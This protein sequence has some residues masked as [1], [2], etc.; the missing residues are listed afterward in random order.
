[1]WSTG[2]VRM[3]TPQRGCG[4]GCG[5]VTSHE[6]A[7]WNKTLSVK[8]ARPCTIAARKLNCDDLRLAAGGLI[9]SH[10]RNFKDCCDDDVQRVNVVFFPMFFACVFFFLGLRNLSDDE[11]SKTIAVCGGLATVATPHNPHCTIDAGWLLISQLVQL[12]LL[13]G[14][15]CATEKVRKKKQ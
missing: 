12:L 1:M 14:N 9:Y 5:F 3:R 15:K 4:C 10:H 11:M 13:A 6:A 2:Q 8:A 7:A